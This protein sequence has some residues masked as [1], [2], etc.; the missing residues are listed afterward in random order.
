MNLTIIVLALMCVLIVAISIVAYTLGKRTAQ[1]KEARQD[2]RI[3]YDQNT[4]DVA[5][6]RSNLFERL[7][8]FQSK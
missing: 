4:V 8:R 7:R 2:A 6:S 3:S 1:E 5:A